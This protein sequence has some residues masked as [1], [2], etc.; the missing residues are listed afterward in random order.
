MVRT[1]F[2]YDICIQGYH[3][4]KS[5]W[6]ASV[7]EILHCSREVDNPNDDHAV[8]VICTGITVGHVPKY[9]SRGF[10]LFIQLGGNI[11]AANVSTRRYSRY[12][13]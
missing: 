8:T 4:S 12:L 11:T 6:D 7:G 9:V 1:N 13:P 2:I 10:S 5:I 3:E